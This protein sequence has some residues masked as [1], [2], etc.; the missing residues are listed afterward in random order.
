MWVPC[1]HTMIADGGDGLQIRRVAAN[2]LNL[3]RGKPIR[4]GLPTWGLGGGLT[5]AH[6]K[7]KQV[8]TK[9]YTGSRNCTDSFAGPRQWKIRKT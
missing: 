1:H 5:T 3:S 2:I 4:G 7:R 8:G 6:R 9:C